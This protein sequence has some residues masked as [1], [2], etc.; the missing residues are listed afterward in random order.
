MSNKK[1]VYVIGAGA[2]AEVNLPTG[3]G[4]KEKISELLNFSL[5]NFQDLIDGDRHIYNALMTNIGDEMRAVYAMP[6]YILAANH[7]RE[8]LPQAISIDNFMDTQSGNRYIELVGKL[9]IARSIL[10]AERNSALYIDI[11]NPEIKN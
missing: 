9:A 6:E 3:A 8:A 11:N 7:I 10:M 4:L 5:N 1:T 2:S